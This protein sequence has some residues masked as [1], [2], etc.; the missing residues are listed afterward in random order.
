ML[1]ILLDYWFLTENKGSHGNLQWDMVQNKEKKWGVFW[2]IFI[3]LAGLLTRISPIFLTSHAGLVHCTSG[4]FT[5]KCQEYQ[6]IPSLKNNLTWG[7]VAFWLGVHRLF[8]CLSNNI[9]SLLIRCKPLATTCRLVRCT[10]SG[11]WVY[12][13]MV[14]GL[15][16]VIIHFHL[17]NW[18]LN[19][20][21]FF[22]CRPYTWGAGELGG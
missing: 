6:Q 21:L 8:N 4:V 3:S 15:I 12:S 13:L 5:C 16:W 22:I 1:H 10:H 19:N 2:K 7:V 11:K 14:G 20:F 9:F 17:F 18:G